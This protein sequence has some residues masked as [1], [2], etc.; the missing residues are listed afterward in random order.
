MRNQ[1]KPCIG[2]SGSCRICCNQRTAGYC[3]AV[4]C[5]IPDLL[6]ELVGRHGQRTRSKK[7]QPETKPPYAA[8]PSFLPQHPGT[9]SGMKQLRN[10]QHPKPWRWAGR[11]FISHPEAQFKSEGHC[12]S[13]RAGRERRN[14]QIPTS[15]FLTC[16]RTQPFKT[17]PKGVLRLRTTVA[18]G[19]VRSRVLSAFGASHYVRWGS[20]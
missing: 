5:A 11:K 10:I 17:S 15:T 1:R 6:A 8:L 2:G 4:H 16:H 18:Y 13:Y 9:K 7:R 14:S 19:G 12:G 3:V 20:R